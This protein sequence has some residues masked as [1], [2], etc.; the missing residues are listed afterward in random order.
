MRKQPVIWIWVLILFSGCFEIKREI[1]APEIVIEEDTLP[2]PPVCKEDSLMVL[3]AERDKLI[4]SLEIVAIS[5]SQ[6]MEDTLGPNR[7][8]LD[9]VT[10]IMY[11][12]DWRPFQDVNTVYHSIFENPDYT[13]DGFDFPV[14]K[15]DGDGYYVARRFMQ[16]NHL[17]DD[18]N[19]RTGG[20]TDL[21]DK[22]YS[23]ANGY[24]CFAMDLKGGW[25]KTV[26]IVH[27]MMDGR[28]VESLY[29]HCD[30]IYVKRGQYVKRGDLIGTIGTAHGQYPA[31]LH[32]ELRTE[33]N[34]PL[35]TGYSNYPDGYVAPTLFIRDNRPRW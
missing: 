2:P 7:V 18:F 30:M 4:D 23:I 15:P 33:I 25:G 17:G 11:D 13:S 12:N 34:M 21:G 1:A 22:V 10:K 28:Y 5:L 6:M 3:L 9:S 32:L 26:R 8:A 16:N 31:H 20:D 27:K 14:G 19:A 29:S 24:V 35:G